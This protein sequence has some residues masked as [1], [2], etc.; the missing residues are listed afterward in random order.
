MKRILAVNILR[1]EDI[2]LRDIVDEE[3][4]IDDT[5]FFNSSSILKEPFR[6]ERIQ[7]INPISVESRRKA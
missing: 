4:P 2:Y 6:S 1:N 7:Y 3:F 5:D